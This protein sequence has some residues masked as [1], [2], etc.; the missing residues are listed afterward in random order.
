MRKIINNLYF[1]TR[2]S[3]INKIMHYRFDMDCINDYE[4]IRDGL[5]YLETLSIFALFK[6]LADWK[7][8]R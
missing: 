4:E 5:K 1:N 8:N 7:Y 2:V 6:T 3:L